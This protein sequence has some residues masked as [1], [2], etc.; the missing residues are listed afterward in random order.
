MGPSA[1]AKTAVAK[2]VKFVE[3]TC[4]C[5]LT[6]GHPCNTLLLL[7][8]YVEYR[9]QVFLISQEMVLLGNVVK[10][11]MLAYAVGIN[12]SKGQGQA[13]DYKHKGYMLCREKKNIYL[14][15]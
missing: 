5:T 10:T 13:L 2:G 7:Q 11:M 4:G 6:D 1:T 3:T 14:S 15:A 12:L 8:Y 9:A